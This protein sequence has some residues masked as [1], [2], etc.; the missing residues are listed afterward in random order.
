MKAMAKEL[1]DIVDSGYVQT[2]PHILAFGKLS[3]ESRSFIKKVL[4]DRFARKT[5]NPVT[6]IH[7]G[8]VCVIVIISF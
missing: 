2:F 1:R 6:V 5:F 7:P 4:H 8:T 3:S